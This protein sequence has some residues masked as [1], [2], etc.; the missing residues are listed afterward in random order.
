MRARERHPERSLAERYTP[1]AMDPILLNAHD[2]LDREV[3][4]PSVRHANSPTSASA[5]DLGTREPR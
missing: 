5:A 4:K 3:H 1:L 2:E